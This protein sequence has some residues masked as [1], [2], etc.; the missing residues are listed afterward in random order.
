MIVNKHIKKFVVYTFLYIY[1]FGLIKPIMPIVNDVIAHTFYK[2]EHL[3]TVHFENGKYHVH[4]ELATE[5]G[6]QNN[7]AKGS[8]QFSSNETLASHIINKKIEFKIYSSST[9]II[10][11]SKK[12]HLPDAYIQRTTPPPKA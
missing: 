9:S 5:A 7:D 2:M 8:N 12:L 3:A 10:I 1:A 11:T 6:K 4:A